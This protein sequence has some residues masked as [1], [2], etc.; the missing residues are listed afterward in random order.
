MR[1]IQLDRT[2][3]CSPFSLFRWPLY[4]LVFLIKLVMFKSLSSELNG[5]FWILVKCFYWLS[6][7]CKPYSTVCYD[8]FSIHLLPVLSIGR[9]AFKIRSRCLK[10]GWV[11][12][13]TFDKKCQI[14]K[15]SSL[16]NIW[17]E[18]YQNSK[19]IFKMSGFKYVRKIEL[20]LNAF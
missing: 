20:Q 4:K 6:Y 11:K 9:A 7:V 15:M 10:S 18:I 2:Y 17:F 14:S 19:L 16:K 3:S 5:L 13:S 12:I 8:S 1:T